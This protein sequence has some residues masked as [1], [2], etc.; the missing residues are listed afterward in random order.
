MCYN[1]LFDIIFFFQ[2]LELFRIVLFFKSFLFEDFDKTKFL[3]FENFNFSNF[4]IRLIDVQLNILTKHI[5]LA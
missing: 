5:G 2:L 3:Q 1:L 4:K